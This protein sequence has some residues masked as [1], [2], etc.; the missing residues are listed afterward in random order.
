MLQCCGP[1][2]GRFGAA[3]IRNAGT[4]RLPRTTCVDC[5][6]RL[7]TPSELNQRKKKMATGAPSMTGD[8]GAVRPGDPSRSCLLRKLSNSHSGHH[9]IVLMEQKVAVIYQ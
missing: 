7:T 8:A 9:A 3:F 6:D 2:S 5:P 1:N 4:A